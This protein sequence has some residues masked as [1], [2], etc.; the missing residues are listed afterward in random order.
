VPPV[1]VT[2]IDTPLPQVPSCGIV[3][4]VCCVDFQLPE[5]APVLPHSTS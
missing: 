5:E 4:V 3:C 1:I 2:F